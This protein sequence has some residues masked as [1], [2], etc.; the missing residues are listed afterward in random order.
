M[1]RARARKPR[2]PGKALRNHRY[3]IMRLARGQAMPAGMIFMPAAFID[4][5]QALRLENTDEN[6]PDAVFPSHHS[7][8]HM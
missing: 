1:D 5:L 3:A 7:R 4:D 8:P 6:T 2:L